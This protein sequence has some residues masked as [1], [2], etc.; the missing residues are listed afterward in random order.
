MRKMRNMRRFGRITRVICFVA[1]A[2]LCTA[3][4]SVAKHFST[5]KF[6]ENCLILPHY[7]HLSVISISHSHKTMRIMRIDEGRVVSGIFLPCMN[8]CR[9]VTQ[10]YEAFMRMN[11]R[12][13]HIF[14]AGI[15]G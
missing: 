3:L 4:P 2:S 12:T 14:I 9:V 7:L 11:N 15:G 13:P 1:M 5:G 8:W 6:W 10:K